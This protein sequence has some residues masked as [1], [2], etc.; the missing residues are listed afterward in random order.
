MCKFKGCDA[1][2]VAKGLCSRHYMR[3][4]RHGSVDEVRKPGRPRDANLDIYRSIFRDWSPRTIA[5]YKR[6]MDILHALGFNAAEGEGRKFIE[7]NTRVNGTLRV[8][9]MLFTA[10][11]NQLMIRDGLT[12]DQVAMTHLMAQG[13]REE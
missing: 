3:E 10:E 11:I 6:T 5:R 1:K 2:P 9:Q 4:R 8:S 12:L 7:A 13:R